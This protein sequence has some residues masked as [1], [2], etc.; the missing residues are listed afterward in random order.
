MNYFITLLKYVEK[1]AL[2]EI[3]NLQIKTNII[4]YLNV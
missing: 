1:S 4:V 3:Q 2:L